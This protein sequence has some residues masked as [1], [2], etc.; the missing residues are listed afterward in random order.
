M[1]TPVYGLHQITYELLYHS[2]KADNLFVEM[3][4]RFTYINYIH[5]GTVYWYNVGKLII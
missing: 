2:I 3:L 5:K 1:I 4:A